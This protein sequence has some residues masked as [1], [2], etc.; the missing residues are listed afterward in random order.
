MEWQFGSETEWFA[1]NNTNAIVQACLVRIWSQTR[2]QKAETSDKIS[3]QHGSFN[4]E[5][6][7]AVSTSCGAGGH[8]PVWSQLIIV[9]KG[10]FRQTKKTMDESRRQGWYPRAARSR[11]D[12]VQLYMHLQIDDGPARNRTRRK[13]TYELCIR[14]RYRTLCHPVSRQEWLKEKEKTRKTESA[15]PF[16]RGPL[17]RQQRRGGFYGSNSGQ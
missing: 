12:C 2:H 11:D 17:P 8:R 6:G 9:S 10:Q 5:R 16:C 7:P 14:T 13:R 15:V 3:Q 4:T 1:A